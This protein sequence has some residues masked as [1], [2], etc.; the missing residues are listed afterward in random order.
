M[1]DDERPDQS[2][3]PRL[4]TRQNRDPNYGDEPERADRERERIDRD[5][6]AFYLIE[7]EAIQL[8]RRRWQTV[9]ET[10]ASARDVPRTEGPLAQ[11]E[12]PE[13]TGTKDSRLNRLRLWVSSAVRPATGRRR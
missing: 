7:R 1:A 2:K 3:A 4:E 8:R 11:Y 12:R 10:T 6:N 9:A 5:G 13:T